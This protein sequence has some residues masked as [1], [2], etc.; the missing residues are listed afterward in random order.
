MPGPKCLACRHPQVA[1]LTAELESGVPIRQICDTY[2]M[3]IGSVHR[4]KQHAERVASRSALRQP[5][6]LDA[7][8][9]PPLTQKRVSTRPVEPRAVR[10]PG[11]DTV[12]PADRPRTPRWLR[13]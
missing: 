5:L 12:A 8:Q 10:E 1:T 7:S 3:S 2:G 4:H 9:E 13:K 6:R 11:D